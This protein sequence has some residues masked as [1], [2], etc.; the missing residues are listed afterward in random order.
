MPPSPELASLL[1][2]F[3][4]PATRSLVQ[5]YVRQLETTLATLTLPSSGLPAQEPLR[6]VHNLKGSSAQL[7]MARLVELL[8]AIE[9]RARPLNDGLTVSERITLR[10][11][12]DSALA[13]LHTWLA[14]GESGESVL[15]E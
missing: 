15:G 7:G 4:E 11:L 12:G 3:G 8:V 10:S 13:E 6:L 9:A 14:S 5:A 1:E 2:L